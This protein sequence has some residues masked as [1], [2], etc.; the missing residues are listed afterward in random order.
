MYVWYGIQSLGFDKQITDKDAFNLLQ[1]SAALRN[2]NSVIELGQDY[3]KGN[4]VKQD[5]AKGV[6]I[7]KLAADQGNK[8]ARIRIEIANLYGEID[9]KDKIESFNY[10]K[11]AEE[12]G[13]L[14]AE[15]S[16]ADCYDKGIIVPRE[17]AK[18]VYYFRS[19]AVRGSVFAYNELKRLYDEIRPKGF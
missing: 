14:I 7:W 4:F 19:A 18:A 8:E 12:K 16:L 17:K 2:L 11:T 3:F 5:K 13:S 15:L 10:L 6:E 9:I 1:K